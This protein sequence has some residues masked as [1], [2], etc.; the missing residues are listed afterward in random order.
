MAVFEPS[1]G[2]IT[3]T[4]ICGEP[5][6]QRVIFL[7]WFLLHVFVSDLICRDQLLNPHNPEYSAAKDLGGPG[8]AN[9]PDEVD[10][11]ICAGDL[12]IGV[13]LLPVLAM[14]CGRSRK[15]SLV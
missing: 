2:A 12:L 3:F 4:T 13:R 15:R 8:F 11:P 1:R 5:P 14:G 9:H 7:L 6:A 10:V